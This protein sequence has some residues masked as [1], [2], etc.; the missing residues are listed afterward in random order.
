MRVLVVRD[1]MSPIDFAH[2][3]LFKPGPVK[4]EPANDRQLRQPGPEFAQS[5]AQLWMHA[6]TPALTRR[7]AVAKEAAAEAAAKKA[8]EAKK[9]CRTG[10]N[11]MPRG[12]RG[13]AGHAEEG[14]SA[15]AARIA[16]AELSQAKLV[17]FA[18]EIEGHQ[19]Q[20][21]GTPGCRA[22]ANRRDIRRREGSNRCRAGGA[23]GGQGCRGSPR[24]PHRKRRRWPLACRFRCSSA[25]RHSVCMS[26]GLSSLC[27]K[28]RSPSASPMRDRHHRLYCH[29]LDGRRCGACVG[30]LCR[31]PPKRVRAARQRGEPAQNKPRRYQSCT[32]PYFHT[33][34]CHRPDQRADLARLIPD[35]LG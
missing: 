3:A 14:R 16:E 20:G 6:V 19:G 12:T 2:P 26:A 22:G 1:D 10:S 29:Q 8:D 25:A 7:S 5:G 27:S 23:R 21:T 24:L 30:S 32:R 15:S 17:A 33:A 18:Q 4:P 13:R 31:C 11:G 9:G 28:A 34:G 35:R